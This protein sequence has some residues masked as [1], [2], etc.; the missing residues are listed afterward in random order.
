[1][2]EFASLLN[3]RGENLGTVRVLAEAAELTYKT[4]TAP[5]QLVQVEVPAH[6]AWEGRGLKRIRKEN[7]EDEAYLAMSS[8][9]AEG[10]GSKVE[11]TFN[12]EKRLVR[13][14]ITVSAALFETG[15]NRPADSLFCRD[16]SCG[17]CE[18]S[19]DG[20][21]KLA[22]QTATHRGMS[23]RTE[24]G[25]EVVAHQTPRFAKESLA[26][27]DILCPC[28]GITRDEVEERLEHGQL[29][30]IEAVL[31]ASPVG[32]GKCHGRLCM[33]PFLRQL[34]AAGLDTD[35]WID[36]RFP[37]SDWPLTRA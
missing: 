2:G 34:Q 24:S 32:Q 30:S 35:S 8:R 10:T 12:G 37:W 23:I 7:A 31:S 28:M 36:W 21:K 4:P 29:K 5:R 6:L 9:S 11:I 14:Q 13:D 27:P 33:D 19:I 15:W 16:G 17:L 25:V 22:C 1:V 20:V 26:D 3:R 18:I